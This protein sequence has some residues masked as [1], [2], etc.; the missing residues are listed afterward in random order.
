MSKGRLL[1]KQALSPKPPIPV[2]Q[3][4]RGQYSPSANEVS[5]LSA[6][7]LVD[8]PLD[9]GRVAGNGSFVEQARG[10]EL[11]RAARPPKSYRSVSKPKERQAAPELQNRKLMQ[12]YAEA[13]ASSGYAPDFLGKKAS[14]ST[15]VNSVLSSAPTNY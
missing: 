4:S 12:D 8:Q 3:S 6:A 2:E 14:S 7:V 5:A 11:P 15:Q 13:A 10:A 1:P 9:A